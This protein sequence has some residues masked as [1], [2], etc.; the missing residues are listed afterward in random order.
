MRDENVL[1]F[2]FTL[3]KDS[4]QQFQFDSKAKKEEKKNDKKEFVDK[5]NLNSVYSTFLIII[6]HSERLIIKNTSN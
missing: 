4:R 6:F 2:F 1:T 3:F 5:R